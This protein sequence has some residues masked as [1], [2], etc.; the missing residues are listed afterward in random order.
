MKPWVKIFQPKDI[1]GSVPGC[2]SSTLWI[3]Q[4][5]IDMN[6]YW[7]KHQYK[8]IKCEYIC[9]QKATPTSESNHSSSAH[10]NFI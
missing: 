6:V 5:N 10:K 2:G 7:N 1:E 8:N 3:L 4:L 9:D